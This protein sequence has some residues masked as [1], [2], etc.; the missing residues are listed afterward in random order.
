MPIVNL[1]HS[2]TNQSRDSS[3]DPEDVQLSGSM[4]PITKSCQDFPLYPDVHDSDPV[5]ALPERG[6][7]STSVT[8]MQPYSHQTRKEAQVHRLPIIVVG[9]TVH[10][11]I[12]GASHTASVR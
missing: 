7:I 1:N 6:P 2:Q 9:F 10:P 5:A 8:K 11:A 4:V 12:F 3:P